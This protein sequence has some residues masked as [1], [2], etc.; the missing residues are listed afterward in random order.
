MTTQS[1]H[2]AII[3]KQLSTKPP[4]H[5]T[6]L[7]AEAANLTMSAVEKFAH[8]HSKKLDEVILRF[9]DLDPDSITDE[10]LKV[11]VQREQA[12]LGLEVYKAATPKEVKHS[13]A[14]THRHTTIERV[15]VRPPDTN[16][17]DT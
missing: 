13:G 5:M 12:K 10:K 6:G 2:P 14:V 17:A 16:S 3:D 15:I 9:V 8:K 7:P 4:K 11:A 1:M